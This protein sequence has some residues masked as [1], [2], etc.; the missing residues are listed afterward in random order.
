MNTP[1]DENK[2]EKTTHQTQSD[3]N[4]WAMF[5]HL[6]GLLGCIIP[7]GNIAVPLVIW[8][9][10]RDKFPLVHDQGKEAVNFQISI[11]LYAIGCIILFFIGIGFLLI[12]ALAI[13]VLATTIMGTIKASSGEKF[14]YPL[15]IRLIQ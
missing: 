3:E 9:T 15:A 4:M 11:T 1:N 2:I 13:F 10:Q 5:C 12:F 14:R 7:L 8:L 6:G